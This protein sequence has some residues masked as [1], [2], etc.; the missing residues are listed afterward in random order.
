LTPS[1]FPRSE[2]EKAIKLQPVLNELM[3]KVAYDTEFLTTTLANTIK[4]DEFTRG[5]FK[6]FEKVLNEGINQVSNV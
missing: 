6:V 5:L 2:F 1:S 3:H 4:V